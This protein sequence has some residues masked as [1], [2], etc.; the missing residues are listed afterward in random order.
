MDDEQAKPPFNRKSNIP[1]NTIGITASAN[2]ILYSL[3]FWQRSGEMTFN[4]YVPSAN[5]DPGPAKGLKVFTEDPHNGHSQSSGR[6][7]NAVPG[8]VFVLGSPLSGS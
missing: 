8:G 4:C 5:V 7:L 6:S 3:F 2:S 1:K